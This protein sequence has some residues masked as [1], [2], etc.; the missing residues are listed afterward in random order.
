ME[1][2]FILKF[3]I[4]FA[5][6]SASQFAY[7]KVPA[8]WIRSAAQ[9]EEVSNFFAQKEQENTFGKDLNKML[10]STYSIISPSAEQKESYGLDKLE[11]KESK[12][13]WYLAS[14]K[15]EVGI[16]ASGAIG[17]VGI[18][19]EAA[20]EYI[21]TRTA[22]SIKNLQK[23]A[24]G[25]KTKPAANIV[26]NGFGGAED[27][28]ELSTDMNQNQLAER[29]NNL[30]RY[31]NR[32]GKVKNISNLKQQLLKQV[33]IHLEYAQQL[34]FASDQMTWKP[35][36]YQLE[37]FIQGSGQVVPTIQVGCV[38]RLRIEWTIKEKKFFTGVNVPKNFI[39][40]ANFITGELS[41]SL[42]DTGK[43]DNMFYFYG[44]KVGLGIGAEGDIGVAQ[45]QAH[46]IAS[47][48]LKYNPPN[49]FVG[50][51]VAT[52][53]G[54]EMIGGLSANRWKSALKKAA[55]MANYITE[56][57]S[58]TEKRMDETRPFR[59]FELGAIEVELELSAEGVLLL[60]T[61]EGI[62]F[63]ELFF[64]K[65]DRVKPKKN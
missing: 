65:K 48:F 49:N 7:S 23:K 44:V 9:A 34:A 28:L 10:K 22:Q 39:A 59:D 3:A 6:F 51:T 35:Y 62:A 19:G 8:S 38:L 15:T 56:Q 50:G 20:V 29:V 30:V 1:K 57:S 24:Y 31:V 17:L 37:V 46:S 14:M 12:G 47:V 13:P 41:R 61:V 42:L 4:L 55:T 2:N 64:N 26:E 40:S 32:S 63:M 5:V 52:Y 33:T 21:W 36:K 54:R 58:V 25:S 11:Q 18:E 60:P 27:N 53:S 16:E 43:N 45:L